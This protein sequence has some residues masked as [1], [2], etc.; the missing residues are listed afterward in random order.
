[1]GLYDNL[2]YSS[3]TMWGFSEST[4]IVLASI[5]VGSFIVRFL[6]STLSHRFVSVIISNDEIRKKAVKRGDA[7]LGTAAASVFAFIFCSI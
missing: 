5:F 4:L 1:M 7:A 3:D 2:T 6:V